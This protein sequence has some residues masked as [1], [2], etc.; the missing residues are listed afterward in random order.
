MSTSKYT[1]VY[2]AFLA[3]FAVRKGVD[4]RRS[5]ARLAALQ[6]SRTLLKAPDQTFPHLLVTH[7]AFFVLTP[8][9]VWL[10]DRPFLPALAFS[11]LALFL[12]ATALRSWSTSLLAEHW[13]SRVAVPEDLQPVTSGPYKVIRH[14]NYLAMSLELLAL[15][16]M[17]SAWLASA[18]VTVLNA[19]SVNMRIWE[20]EAVL[21]QVPAYKEAM[22]K[23][24]RLIPGIY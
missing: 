10:L 6:S 15:G 12:V 22:E 19:I 21:F 23:T 2:F 5:R 17:H 3:L 18:V 11:M 8:L 1:W 7:L 24:A 16:L 9:E 20:E 13:S 4:Q 14:P